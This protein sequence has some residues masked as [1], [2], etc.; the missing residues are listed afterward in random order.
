MSVTLAAIIQIARRAAARLSVAF[1]AGIVATLA[2]TAMLFA[3]Q[4]LPPI[5]ILTHIRTAFA[6][7]AL[8]ERD[9][10]PAYDRLGINQ[11]N[12]C[13]LVQMF[14]FRHDAWADTVAPIVIFNDWPETLRADNGQQISECAIARSAA[15]SD[16]PLA[17]YPAQ[18]YYAYG[19][20]IHAFRLPAY[21]LLEKF[22]VGVI[23]QFYRATAFG[24]LGM[25]LIT[26]MLLILWRIQQAGD[27]IRDG[28][29]I[30]QAIFFIMLSMILM[31]FYGLAQYS[32]SLTHAPSDILIFVAI[33]VISVLN[34]SRISVWM[35]CALCGIFGALVFALEFLHG[36]L[37]LGLAALIACIA[38]KADRQSS[39]RQIATTVFVSGSSFVVGACAGLLI[40]IMTLALTFGPQAVIGF[41]SQL[42]YRMRGGEGPLSDVPE[43]LG[44]NL[45]LI[46]FE[47]YRISKAFLFATGLLLIVAFGI[48]LARAT[49][50]LAVQALVLLLSVL[51]I[52]VWYSLFRNHTVI[53]AFFMVRLLVWPL[54]ATAG[55]VIIAL[56]ACARSRSRSRLS[57][58]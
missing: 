53:H 15:F 28:D 39:A 12:D 47:D 13:L 43:S 29:H 40:K 5:G 23:R 25:I 30:I 35:L 34:I 26:Q 58:T 9:W 44:Q 54:I 17:L 45:H 16:T 52:V 32:P 14:V 8:Q 42:D 6:N 57:D 19:R 55:M 56:S 27:S 20:Y 38:M 11:Y 3:M 46:F 21:L 49:Q 10:L 7:G 31:R 41:F 22:D 24:V 33:A 36:A 48:V 1:L 4:A 37:P 50:A 2:L 51:V 18:S